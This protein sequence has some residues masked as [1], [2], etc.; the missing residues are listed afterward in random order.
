MANLSPGPV[1]ENK[2]EAVR[3]RFFDKRA[4]FVHSSCVLACSRYAV[5]LTRQLACESIVRGVAR[6]VG[7]NDFFQAFRIIERAGQ[8]W[9]CEIKFR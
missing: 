6:L 2:N 4:S 3:G 8:V 1:A 7:P 5:W 9:A